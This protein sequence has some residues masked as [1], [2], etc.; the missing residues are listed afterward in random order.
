MSQITLI[1]SSQNN[2]IAFSGYLVLALG[3]LILAFSFTQSSSK[4]IENRP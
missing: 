4:C 1:Q 2:S 3:Y